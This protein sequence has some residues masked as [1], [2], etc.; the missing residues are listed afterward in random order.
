[1]IVRL[2][3][4]QI[5]IPSAGESQARAF[6]LDLLGLL[7]IPKPDSLKARGGFWLSLAGQEIHVSLEENVNRLATKAHVAFE[8]ADLEFWR[9][10]LTNAG[11][12]ILDGVFIPGFARFETRDPFGNR[13]E[14][15]A[16]I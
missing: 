6:Y 2:H 8:V 9:S 4:L 3:H 12:E 14:L 13:L 10:K 11:F 5:T 16:R 1:M 7:E 15:I